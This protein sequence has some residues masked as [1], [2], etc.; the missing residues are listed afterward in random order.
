MLHPYAS[1]T[2]VNFK[3]N[4]NNNNNHHHLTYFLESAKTKIEKQY[5]ICECTIHKRMNNRIGQFL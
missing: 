3:N 1:F 5:Q 4:N 2:C